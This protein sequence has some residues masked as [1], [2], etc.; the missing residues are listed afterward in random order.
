[1]KLV[2]YTGSD[3]WSALY[4]DGKLD[5]VG[6][7]YLIDERIQELVGVEVFDSNDFLLG[8]DSLSDVAE[9]LEEIQ[10]YTDEQNVRKESIAIIEEEIFRLQQKI[11]TLNQ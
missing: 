3:E 7:H 6:D 5:K 11:K 9:T 10:K 2:R 1:M 8:G 4:I